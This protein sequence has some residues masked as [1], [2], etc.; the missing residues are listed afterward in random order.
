MKPKIADIITCVIKF[1]E[2]NYRSAIK[3]KESR[4]KYVHFQTHDTARGAIS[5]AKHL[6]KI[7]E[8]QFYGIYYYES[9]SGQLIH[10]IGKRLEPSSFDHVAF[11]HIDLPDELKET[12]F[13]EGFKNIDIWEYIESNESHKTKYLISHKKDNSILNHNITDYK[14]IEHSDEIAKELWNRKYK[15]KLKR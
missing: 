1:G 15:E 6:S 12:I 10:I 11:H 9:S 4:T 2:D 5:H 3:P 7:L 14:I 8:K 13:E